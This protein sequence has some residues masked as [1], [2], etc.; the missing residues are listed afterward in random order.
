MKIIDISQVLHNDIPVWPG[1]TPFSFELSWTKEASGSVNVGK[2]EMSAHTGTHIDA[3]FHFDNEGKKVIELDLE[4]YIGPALV[5]EK[6]NIEMLS[7]EHFN[8]VNFEGVSRILIKTG[9]W[10]DQSLFPSSIPSLSPDLAPFLAKKGIK[11]I[12]VDVPSVD[13]LDS[14]ELPAHHSLLENDIH[15][16][17]GIVLD[18]VKEGIYELVALPLPIKE[19]DGSPVRAVLIER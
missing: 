4:L 9:S 17:E 8:D 19:A 7:P 14:K 6:K 16:L 15:I 12:G 5:V 18:S 10:I 11:L 13:M 3:P 1:D 2:I